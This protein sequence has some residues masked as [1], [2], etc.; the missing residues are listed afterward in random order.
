[1]KFWPG[2]R[3]RWELGKIKLRYSRETA[4]SGTTRGGAAAE[5]AF[6]GA[7]EAAASGVAETAVPSAA[8]TAASFAA[9]TTVSGMA[10]C[11]TLISLSLSLRR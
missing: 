6:P 3:D 4:E 7:A 1:M 11:H 8:E 9:G 5:T 10:G 2:A